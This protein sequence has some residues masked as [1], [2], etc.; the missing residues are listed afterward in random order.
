MNRSQPKVAV[1]GSGLA[2]HI[3][4]AAVADLGVDAAL[5]SGE[6]PGIFGIWNGIGSVFGPP[7]PMPA[8]SAGAPE[9]RSADQR[10]FDPARG[11]RW[12]R[13]LERRGDFHPY[14]RFEFDR[15]DVDRAIDE[16]L[17]YL[18]N[19]G[20]VRVDGGAV[21][22]GPHGQPCA[23][24]LAFPSLTPLDVGPGDRV[25]LV[26]CPDLNG[27]DADAAA[28]QLD[29]AAD[30]EARAV[31]SSL[32]A[33]APAGHGVRVARWIE[34][35]IDEGG[36]ECLDTLGALAANNDLDLLVLPPAVG[37]TIEGHRSIWGQLRERVDVPVAE[38]PAATDPVFGWRLF[39]AC[40]DAI[41]ESTMPRLPAAASVGVSGG[42][43]DTVTD[44]DG[45][46]HPCD[47]I[48]LATG[49]WFG[50]GA[51]AEP[52]LVE[53][54]TGAP[55]WLDGAPLPDDEELYPPNYLGD[56][57]WDDHALFRTGVQVDRTGR[58]LGRD[59]EPF[60]NVFAAGRLLAGFNPFHDDCAFGVELTTGL[61]AGRR[62]TDAV[63][64]VSAHRGETDSLETS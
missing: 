15:D 38:F 59:G 10:P 14:R 62:A 54:L 18:P 35:R 40:R 6:A 24:D 34:K 53:P 8:A 27:W 51:P 37:A 11:H 45:A 32:F 43:A 39:R 4:A 17:P 13:L 25:G 12:K 49:R 47:A 23:P 31:D 28:L 19:Q 42:R 46:E 1:V 57:P 41:V 30:L 29:R 55:I 63:S 9:R 5:F 16:A 60:D 26:R 3:A 33:G 58:V 7:S 21:Y 64:D 61:A 20:L 36:A 48:V 50:G 52:P 56:L 22:P 2:A 44:A